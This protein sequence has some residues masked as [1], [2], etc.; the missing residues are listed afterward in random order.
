MN[1]VRSYWFQ[2]ATSIYLFDLLKKEIATR[3]R[4]FTLPGFCKEKRNI[5]QFIAV[6]GDD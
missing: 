3:T 6:T 5:N 2:T 4:N 1:Q